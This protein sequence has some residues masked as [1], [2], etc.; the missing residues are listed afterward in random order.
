MNKDREEFALRR[1]TKRH[2][3][4]K[5][6]HFYGL[7]AIFFVLF[8]VIGLFA[9]I[10]YRGSGAFVVTT[11]TFD[12][13]FDRHVLNINAPVAT[14][15]ALHNA[16]YL[17]LIKQTLS[18]HFPQ[19]TSRREKKQLY[20]L[21]SHQA[22]FTLRHLL[23]AQPELLGTSQSV[24]LLASDRLHQFASGNSIYWSA[25]QK[26]WMTQLQQENRLQQQ[27]NWR[28]FTAGDS[29]FP[30]AAGILSALTGSLIALAITFLLSFP[31]GI[32][33]A[34]Y[35]EEF[36]P[37]R[38]WVQWIEVNINN[39]AAVPSIIFGLLG[40]AVLINLFGLP[41]SAPV[42]GG[43][44]L[45]MLTLPTIIIASR[46]ALSA[47]PLSIREAAIAMGV[48]KMQMVM[49]HVVPI[50]I[51]GMLTGS[52]IGM[53]GALGESAPLL[54]I[55]MVA[56]VADPPMSIYEPATALPVQVYLWADSPE[57]GFVERT[58]GAIIVLLIFLI[59]MNAISTFLRQRLER[60]K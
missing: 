14:S 37:R 7:C 13:H 35:L 27:F 40:L 44:V 15:E 12:I 57:R 26:E 55:G 32:G 16:N 28:F 34:I 49:H 2:R 47:V 10:I 46:S 36:A 3:K 22:E 4:E 39:L 5:R 18:R 59:S 8:C 60:N 56:F 17:A 29:R 50:A 11:V 31:I 19:V 25:Q 20:Q 42:V 45:S 9:I 54:L 21:I 6:F 24:S 51:P 48:S 30:E 53:A 52:I 58:W 1:L 33:A 38:R 41:R 23:I 43:M